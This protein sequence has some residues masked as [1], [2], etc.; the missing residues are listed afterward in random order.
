MSDIFREVD[1]EVR[2]S[3]AEQLWSKYSGIILLACVV[4]VA[5]VAGYRFLEWQR[6]T[7]A[8]AAGAKFEEALALVQS[9]KTAEGEAAMAKIAGGD[10]GIYKS[11]AQFRSAADLAKK[12]AAGALKAFDAL[13]NDATL[14]AGLRDVARLRAGAI[15]VDA[16]PFA[17][18]ERRMMPLLSP[19]NVW[20][21]PANELLAASALKAGELEKASK[22]L[23]TIILD[24]EAPAAVKSRAEVLIGLTRG[25]K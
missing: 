17:E 18:A 13:A 1:E 15:A 5:G 21:H 12:D 10:A 14:D 22:Y 3:Q 6:E 25:A 7:A 19:N 23:D 11:L 20:R 2:R 16:L 24:R 4:L 8:A 9:G